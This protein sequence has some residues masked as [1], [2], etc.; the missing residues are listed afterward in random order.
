MYDIL[1]SSC[2]SEPHDVAIKNFAHYKLYLQIL[3]AAQYQNGNA[4]NM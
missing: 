1:C 3:Y 4:A 2:F